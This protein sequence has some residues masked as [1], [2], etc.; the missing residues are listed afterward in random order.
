ME[1]CIYIIIGYITGYILSYGTLFGSSQ[2]LYETKTKGKQRRNDIK[3]CLFVSV[4]SWASLI[5][6]IICLFAVA[7]MDGIPK[8][9]LI[10]FGLY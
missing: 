10:K 9:G 2:N 7:S 5:M 6:T 4:L 8:K 1:T 3:F